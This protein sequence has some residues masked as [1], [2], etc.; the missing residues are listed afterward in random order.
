MSILN[1]V[2]NVFGEGKKEKTPLPKKK[3]SLPL[4]TKLPANDLGMSIDPTRFETAPLPTPTFKIKQLPYIT[5]TAK[6]GTEYFP[7]QLTPS[8]NIIKNV[9]SGGVSQQLPQPPQIPQQKVTIPTVPTNKFGLNI[10]P[11]TTASMA[12]T[13]LPVSK[14]LP[15]EPVKKFQLPAPYKDRESYLES[16]GKAISDVEKDYIKKSDE[17]ET[18]SKK[19]EALKMEALNNDNKAKS[20][21]NGVEQDYIR[22]Q[23]EIETLSK[24][25]EALK[26]EDKIDEFNKNV[27]IFNAKIEDIKK[28]EKIYNDLISNYNLG[29]NDEFNKNINIFNEKLQ[30]FK[31]TEKTYTDLISNYNLGIA[32]VNKQIKLPQQKY[33]ETISGA[34]GKE[35][36]IPAK[37]EY[38]EGLQKGFS[39]FKPFTKWFTEAV[40]ATVDFGKKIGQEIQEM[41]GGAFGIASTYAP[42]SEEELVEMQK[43]VSDSLVGTLTEYSEAATPSLISGVTMD[44]IKGEKPSEMQL[45]HPIVSTGA[46]F[47]GTLFLWTLMSPLG[48][49]AAQAT[50]SNTGTMFP[51]LERF[52]VGFVRRAVTIA[53]IDILKVFVNQIRDSK[54]SPKELSGELVKSLGRSAVYTGA[55]APTGLTTRIAST[56]AGTAGFETLI[57]YVKNKK[58]TEKDITESLLYGLISSLF[59]ASGKTTQELMDENSVQEARRLGIVHIMNR[60]SSFSW[61][62]ASRNFDSLNILTQLSYAEQVLPKDSLERVKNVINATNL[63]STAVTGEPKIRAV[64]ILSQENVPATFQNLNTE[65]KSEV[66]SNVVKNLAEDILTGKPV[67]IVDKFVEAIQGLLPKIS[68]GISELK[69]DEAGFVSIPGI[70]SATEQVIPELLQPFVE[71]TKKLNVDK[72]TFINDFNEGLKEQDPIRRENA[73]KINEY[74]KTELEQTPEQFYDTYIEPKEELAVDGKQAVE[75]T[76]S[77]QQAIDKAGSVEEFVE[78]QGETVYHGS[79]NTFDSFD[80]SKVGSVTDSGMFGKG[81]YFTDSIKEATLYARGGE[82]KRVVLNLRKPYIINSKSDIPKINVPDKTVED[83]KNADKAY[84]ELFTKYLKEKGYDGVIDNLNPKNKQYVVFS[85]DQIKTEVELTDIYNK[86]KSQPAKPILPTKKLPPAPVK[87]AVEITPSMQQAIDKAGSAEEFVN[88]QLGK[89]YR[90]AHQV[91]AKTASPITEINNK[92]LDTFIDEFKNQYGYPALKSKEVSKLKSIISNPD[93]E[94]TIYRASPKNELNSGD[95]V[96]IDKAYAN[97]IKK[98]NGG[99]VYSHTVK[100]SDLFYP[101]TMKEFKELPS[102]NKWG[103]FQYQSSKE[104]S[105]LTDIYNKYKSQPTKPILPTKK[106]PPEQVKIAD[107]LEIKPELINDRLTDIANKVGRIETGN[108]TTETPLG[109]K[110]IAL[111]DNELLHTDSPGKLFSEVSKIIKQDTSLTDEMKDKAIIGVGESIKNLNVPLKIP[112]LSDLESTGKVYQ[113]AVEKALPTKAKA[114]SPKVDMS[115]PE[116]VP[117][118]SGISGVA[119]LKKVGLAPLPGV[120]PSAKVKETAQTAKGLITKKET[121]L[122]KDKIKN[123]ARGYREGGVLTRDEIKTVRDEITNAIE[124]LEAKDKEKFS[125]K[126]RS[127]QTNEQLKK[128]MPDIKEKVAQ[129]D[130]TR[131]KKEVISKIQDELKFKKTVEKK[132]QKM[133]GKYDYETNKFISE[134]RDINKLN[135]AGAMSAL[136]NFLKEDLS[137]FDLIKVRLISLKANGLKSSVAL[138]DQVAGDIQMLKEYGADAKDEADLKRKIEQTQKIDEVSDAIDKQKKSNWLFKAPKALYTSSGVNLYSSLNAIAGK[139]IA[140]KYDYGNIKTNSQYSAH[141]KIKAEIEKFKEIYDIKSKRK[142]ANIYLKS[143]KGELEKFFLKYLTKPIGNII[144]SSGLPQE[145]TKFNLLNIY[146]GVKNDLIKERYENEFGAKQV[147]D[148]LQKLDEKDKQM[149][150]TMMETVQSYLPVMNK[151]NIEMTGRDVGVVD[152]YWP[153]SSKYKAPFFDDIKIQGETPSALKHRSE[154]AKLTPKID[155]AYTVHQKYIYD[156]EHIKTVSSKYEELK[157]IFTDSD[158]ELKITNKFGKE[159]Y[160]SLMNN[161]ET[162]SFNQ[163][164]EMRGIFAKHYNNALNKWVKAVIANPTIAARGM[165]SSIYSIEKVGIVNYIK[166]AKDFVAH[167]KK[168]FDFVWNNVPYLESRFEIGYSEALEDVIRGAGKLDVEM[169]LYT[170]DVSFLARGSDILGAI[171]SGYPV[172]KTELAKHGDMEKAVDVFE[173]FTEKTQG[174]GTDTNLSA[175]QR[176]KNVFARTFFRF[177]NVLTQLLRLQADAN[178]QFFNG[179]ISSGELLEKTV[180]YSIYTPIMYVLMGM[181]VRGGWKKL[182]GKESDE[183]ENWLGDIFEQVILQPFAAIPILDGIIEWAYKETRKKITGKDYYSGGSMFNYPLLDDIS[184]AG[185]KITKKEI[186]L[187]DII[188][189]FSLIQQPVT[190]FPSE[191]SRRYYKYATDEEELRKLPSLPSSSSSSSPLPGRSSLPKRSLP[192]RSLPSRSLPKRR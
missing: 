70:K 114:V 190:S 64:E 174:S 125:K 162:M 145:I 126:I 59:S 155:N 188:E 37:Y 75:I 122:L 149:A 7:G 30:D 130:E 87:Q 94:V 17:I 96:T 109:K 102:L 53:P 187:E 86:Y 134:L 100:A 171:I 51:W 97:D 73:E 147:N 69:T 108:F 82:V 9:V 60:N 140:D 22:K 81:F 186:T 166:Y 10:K 61:D 31:K 116:P 50:A 163:T 152:N 95:W 44:L 42:E 76:P 32:E 43:E 157:R 113:P 68:K 178:I 128:A 184:R 19:M 192:K 169:S 92:T 133:V 181:L 156:A 14:A 132:G 15:V 153:A 137:N 1:N 183:F 84:S 123:I 104:I 117:K 112:E 101:T 124:P 179:Q 180:L 55:Q 58:V 83:I 127:I 143:D 144:N 103:A 121:T 4:Q 56:F 136:D 85:Q 175:G 98:Q 27:S 40:P 36:G 35:T 161:I 142:L 23:T 185:S 172:L 11:E 39:L 165:I 168:T 77:M 110:I 45:K 170:R 65:H 91:D 29:A 176:S 160:K 74:I 89:D 99:K 3:Q 24:K 21:I 48:D 2:L 177:K 12:T 154:S 118:K 164:S 54:L 6:T 78:G 141:R 34:T 129:L 105:Q 173:K 33:R 5:P 189:V 16:G 25:M 67:N 26:S 115:L 79:P 90:S 66:I 119:G 28:T 106:L 80:I 191:A 167:P 72:K 47:A 41:P 18:L 49:Q 62:E 8:N 139:E 150:D 182:F 159:A 88:S 138:I 151:R 71:Q 131:I 20:V 158:I 111:K 107:Q 57:K 38:A 135:Q 13:T 52:K 146:N 63:V 93:A 148:L 120:S 46:D